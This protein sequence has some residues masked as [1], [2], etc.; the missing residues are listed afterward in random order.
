L[1]K[2]T[3]LPQGFLSGTKSEAFMLEA[4]MLQIKVVAKFKWNKFQK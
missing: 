1:S 3:V 2:Q 4:E